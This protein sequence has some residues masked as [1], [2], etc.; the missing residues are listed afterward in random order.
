M[1]DT[2][3][4]WA[5]LDYSTLVM[6]P[7]N[8]CRGAAQATHFSPAAAI[9]RG[10][11]LRGQLVVMQDTLN[12]SGQGAGRAILVA[13]HNQLTQQ[14]QHVHGHQRPAN[15]GRPMSGSRHASSVHGVDAPPVH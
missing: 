6:R 10:G 11:T 9:W 12:R 5:S 4:R 8:N 7:A 15:P 13:T 14:H 3:A 2:Q 1:S